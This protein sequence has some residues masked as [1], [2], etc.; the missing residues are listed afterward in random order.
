MH[1]L[2]KDKTDLKKK[3]KHTCHIIYLYLYSVM[4]WKEIIDVNQSNPYL[5]FWRRIQT[6]RRIYSSS[7]MKCTMYKNKYKYEIYI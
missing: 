4:S 6:K 2:K 3:T 5:I 7:K 1:L